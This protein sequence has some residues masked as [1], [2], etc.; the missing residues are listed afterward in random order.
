MT[1]REPDAAREH[2]RV[3]RFIRWA[4][5]WDVPVGFG[6]VLTIDAGWVNREWVG[7]LGWRRSYGR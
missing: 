4:F 2:L 1:T 6:V 5:Y 3:P 7:S